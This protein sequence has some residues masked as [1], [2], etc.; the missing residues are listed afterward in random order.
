MADK[1]KPS[2]KSATNGAASKAVAASDPSAVELENDAPAAATPGLPIFYQRPEVLNP[3]PH[4]DLRLKETGDFSFA[5]ETNAI[6][7]NVAEFPQAA[8]HYPIVFVNADAPVSMAV[9]GLRIGENVFVEEDKSWTPNTYIPAYVRRYPFV[10]L[11]DAAAEKLT[12]C[13]DRASTALSQTEG[14][15]LFAG[16]EMSD[17]TKSALDF[18]IAYQRQALQSAAVGALLKEADLLVVNSGRFTLPSGEQLVLTDFLVIDENKLNALSDEA[19]AKLRQNGAL[20][21]IYMH[22][23][24]LNNW[25]ELVRLTK[26]GE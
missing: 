18:C 15:A 21:A 4:G 1:K 5:A 8:H 13:V 26:S 14:E 25:I 6:P 9:T 22:F 23:A 20:A 17:V 3:G 7:L 24:S 16:D 12:L 2:G 11:R 10:F 19:F